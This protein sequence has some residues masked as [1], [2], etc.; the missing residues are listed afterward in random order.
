[1]TALAV[2]PGLDAR[3]EHLR[4][5]TAA[6]GRCCCCLRMR[7]LWVTRDGH[8]VCVECDAGRTPPSAPRSTLIAD[9]TDP[10]EPRYCGQCGAREFLDPPCDCGEQ[11][12]R[13]EQAEDRRLMR[14][15]AR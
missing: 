4:T 2:V 10:E 14:T 1:M 3:G 11:E 6:P 5:T 9:S 12:L 8:T 15:S 7:C 13:A